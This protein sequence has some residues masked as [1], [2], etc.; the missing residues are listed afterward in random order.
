VALKIPPPDFRYVWLMPGPPGAA[1][2]LAMGTMGI[3]AFAIAL[4]SGG[5]NPASLGLTLLGGAFSALFLL[6]SEPKERR[7]VREVAMAIVPW[8]VLVEPDTEPR[9][10]HWPAVRKISVQVSHSMHGGTPSVLSSVVTVETEREI[11]AGQTPGPAG[12]EGLMVH[13]DAYTDEAAR[14]V[15]L[16]LEGFEA[17]GEGATFPVVADLLRRAAELCS[18]A[19][20]AAELGL[21]AGGYRTIAEPTAAP[22]TVALLRRILTSGIDAAPPADPRPLAAIVAARLGASALVPDL[23]RLVSSPHPVVAAVAKAAA[24]RLGAARNRAG[25]IDEVA[26]FLFEEDYERILRFT[27][28]PEV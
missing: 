24:I 10:L 23:L 3:G 13:L 20:G 6:R 28:G 16:D 15:A 25:A 21:P 27:E 22:E 4:W 5:Q 26:A 12:L 9:V 11:F 1:F 18:T 8:G 19:R 14:P 2:A 7:G 17:A